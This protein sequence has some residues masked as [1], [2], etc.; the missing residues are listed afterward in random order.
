MK[1]Q[2]RCLHFFPCEVLEAVA[3]RARTI[4]VAASRKMITQPGCQQG[5]R[6]HHKSLLSE[7]VLPLG[8]LQVA[9]QPRFFP[10]E[11]HCKYT[12]A[13]FFWQKRSFPFP[14]SQKGSPTF[15][16]HLYLRSLFPFSSPSLWEAMITLHVFLPQTA[17]WHFR[18]ISETPLF[19]PCHITPLNYELVEMLRSWADYKWGEHLL[20][21]ILGIFSCKLHLQTVVPFPSLLRKPQSMA[22]SVRQQWCSLRNSPALGKVQNASRWHMFSRGSEGNE[23]KIS[24]GWCANVC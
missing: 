24:A 7:R 13:V 3:G 8:G 22:L 5:A 17:S 2:K 12:L 14:R 1:D 6:G 23:V 4:K 11:L 19:Y 16:F 15:F 20:L 21:L 10:P 9:F 18:R